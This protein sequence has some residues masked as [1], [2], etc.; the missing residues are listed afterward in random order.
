MK[1]I[2]AF[3]LLLGAQLTF[4]QTTEPKEQQSPTQTLPEKHPDN[5]QADN[6][7]FTPAEFPGGM[8]AIRKHISNELNP[9]KFSD[10]PGTYR[11]VT[12]FDI[13]PDGSMSSISTTGNS[14]A[15]NEEVNRTMKKLKTK[16][17]PATKNGQ[18]VKSKFSMPMGWEV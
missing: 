1:K 17:K 10:T 5:S 6:E 12:T 14:P 15:F 3:I 9:S 18:P 7:V 4:S 13:N 16:W 8:S 11:S 2:A